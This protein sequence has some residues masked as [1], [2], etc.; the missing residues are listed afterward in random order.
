MLK[1]SV[2][3]VND[4]NYDENYVQICLD[5]SNNMIFSFFGSLSYEDYIFFFGRPKITWLSLWLSWLLNFNLY[6]FNKNHLKQNKINYVWK[7]QMSLKLSIQKE[8]RPWL[9]FFVFSKNNQ[10]Q[11][12]ERVNERTKQLHFIYQSYIFNKMNLKKFGIGDRT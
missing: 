9:R 2:C 12:F 8:K 3:A 6:N 7:F 4:G 5:E 1:I 10:R 11:H